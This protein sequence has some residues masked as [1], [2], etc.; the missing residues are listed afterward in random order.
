ME[1]LYL[2]VVTKATEAGVLQHPCS[3]HINVTN[4]VT[5]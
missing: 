1:P 2:P 4:H 3:F 5:H